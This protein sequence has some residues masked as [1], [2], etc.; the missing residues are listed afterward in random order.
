MALK[1]HTSTSHTRSLLETQ[2]SSFNKTKITQ[3]EVV[4]KK[5]HTSKSHMSNRHTSIPPLVGVFICFLCCRFKGIM[6]TVKAVL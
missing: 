3:V 6:F 1:S 4:R 2:K 5:R